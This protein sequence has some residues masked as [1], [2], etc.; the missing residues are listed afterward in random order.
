MDTGAP[1][2]PMFIT[3]DA[4]RFECHLE[5]PLRLAADLPKE[6]S[7]REAA[8]EYARLLERYTRLSPELWGGWMRSTPPH[9]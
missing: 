9:A 7:R 6:V 2:V 3:R 4:E 1:L 8:H 5:A